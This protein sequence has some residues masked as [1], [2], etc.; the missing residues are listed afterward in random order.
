MFD[1]VKVVGCS[2]NSN[3]GSLVQLVE[4]LGLTFNVEWKKKT[5][6][7]VSWEMESRS[8][9]LRVSVFLSTPSKVPEKGRSLPLKPPKVYDYITIFT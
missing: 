9:N 1:L 4:G 2:L 8:C 3:K 7:H 5:V 6:K